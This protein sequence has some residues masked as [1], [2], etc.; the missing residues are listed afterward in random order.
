MAE[1]S[2]G[3]R[4]AGNLPTL[5]WGLG[6]GPLIFYV[7]FWLCVFAQSVQQYTAIVHSPQPGNG[8]LRLMLWDA[9]KLLL[10]QRQ[11]CSGFLGNCSVERA[12]L[13][14]RTELADAASPPLRTKW[15]GKLSRVEREGWN[16]MPLPHAANFGL[17]LRYALRDFFHTYAGIHT[18]FSV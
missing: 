12:S 18:K 1:A 14:S 5:V 7:S 13:G 8:S 6:A 3:L 2:N 4:H 9:E 16:G 10:W 17:I 11:R 15:G